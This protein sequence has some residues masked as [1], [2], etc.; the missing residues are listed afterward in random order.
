MRDVT[1]VTD[2]DHILSVGPDSVVL[3]GEELAL[4]GWVVSVALRYAWER[5]AVA[6]IVSDQSVSETVTELARRFGVGLFTTAAGIDRTALALARELGAL[7]AGV[8][9]RLDALHS[10]I[11]TVT[12]VADLLSL[13]SRELGSARVD[14]L[15]GGLVLSSAGEQPAGAAEMRLPVGPGASA[16][17]LAAWVPP[18]QNEVAVQALSRAAP[19]VR[20]LLLEQEIHDLANAAPLLSFTA[21]TGIEDRDLDELP[22]TTTERLRRWPAESPLAVAVF[23]TREDNAGRVGPLLSHSWRTMFPHVPLAR[24]RSAWFGFVPLGDSSADVLAKLRDVSGVALSG[25]R[26]AVGVAAD[27]AGGEEHALLLRRAWLAARLAEPD[28]EAVEFQAMG[29]AMI[30]RLLPAEDAREMAEIAYPALVG[31]AHSAEIADAVL[32]YLDCAGSVA[33]AAERLG[34]HRNTMQARLR[35]AAELGVRLDDPDQMLATHLL[36][37]AFARS[38][39]PSDHTDS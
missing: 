16:Q 17:E 8:L 36:L 35:R 38:P 25:L 19:T 24:T 32:A 23:R 26:V 28:G 14:L 18:A 6:L 22:A 34:I 12:T 29:P 39:A 7:E 1:L 15:V 2:V 37:S 31:D 20:A 5:R 10:R 9:T 21:L 11:L 30:A 27:T 33:G 13:L 4:G 3:L